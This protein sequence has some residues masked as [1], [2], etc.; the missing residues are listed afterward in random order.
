MNW[1]GLNY[2]CGSMRKNALPLSMSCL[3]SE[4]FCYLFKN[5]KHKR[6]PCPSIE[7]FT[8]MVIVA[9]FT[10]AKNWSQINCLSTDEWIMKKNIERGILLRS[11]EK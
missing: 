4:I 11:K 6:T 10:V 1:Q 9:P 5:K 3:I 7:I 8:H 2:K